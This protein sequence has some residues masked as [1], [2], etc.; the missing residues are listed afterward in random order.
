MVLIAITT[1][2][3]AVQN[4]RLPYHAATP[5][6]SKYGTAEL[7]TMRTATT[8]RQRWGAGDL[9]SGCTDS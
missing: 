6:S 3:V 5:L 8:A 2:V 9:V 7:S 4:K 1:A